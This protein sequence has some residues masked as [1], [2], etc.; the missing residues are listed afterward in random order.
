MD[1]WQIIVE[2]A[3]GAMIIGG[4]AI[5]AKRGFAKTFLNG[6]KSLLVIILA[7]TFTPMLSNVC[8]EYLVSGWFENTI[9]PTFVET[10]E[11]AGEYFT[12]ENI[13]EGMPEEERQVLAMVDPD[14]SLQN[15]EGNGVE[16]ATE[17]GTRLENFV[18]NIVSYVITY[19]ALSI[20]LSILLSIL[21]NFVAKKFEI[22]VIKTLNHVIGGIWGLIV[23]YIETSFLVS[24]VTL[25]MSEAMINGTI[26]TKFLYEYGLFSFLPEMIL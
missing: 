1:N 11:Q 13:C 4:V 23:A 14:G 8:S 21:V 24:I 17:L 9:T 3:L 7:L 18:S 22:P 16:L 25:F 5:N 12:F 15:Y 10:A 26:I 6:L 20:V 2:I 19:I